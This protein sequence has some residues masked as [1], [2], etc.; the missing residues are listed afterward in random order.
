MNPLGIDAV[1]PDGLDLTDSEPGVTRVLTEEGWEESTYVDP[2]EDWRLHNDG[3]WWSPDGRTRSWPLS[4]PEP[5]E[6][7]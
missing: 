1:E 2:S 3:S 4:G 6:P 5:A 7:P